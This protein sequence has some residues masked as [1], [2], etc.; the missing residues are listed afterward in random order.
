LSLPPADEDDDG[1][2]CNRCLSVSFNILK[3]MVNLK[4]LFKNLT[5][6]LMVLSNVLI[7][8]GYFIPF[9]YVPIRARELN[10]ENGSTILSTIG[11]K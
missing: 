11:K 3:E 1:S 7:F 4:L 2:C 10:F 9:I 6:A 5:F 8:S